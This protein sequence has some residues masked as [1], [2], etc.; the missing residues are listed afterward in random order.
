[1]H[2]GG[3][4]YR[5]KKNKQTNKL[6]ETKEEE[7][8]SALSFIGFLMKKIILEVLLREIQVH[9]K[10]VF[11]KNIIEFSMTKNYSKF[12]NSPTHRSENYKSN[13]MNPYSLTAFQ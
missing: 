11:E 4:K 12:F 1:M 2:F 5:G 13:S 10:T 8:D 9:P 3:V 6:V 7:F